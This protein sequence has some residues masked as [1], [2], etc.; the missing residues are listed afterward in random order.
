MS[1]LER[2]R[3]YILQSWLNPDNNLYKAASLH[4]RWSLAIIEKHQKKLDKYDLGFLRQYTTCSIMWNLEHR[5]RFREI[6]YSLSY[7]F[8]TGDMKI[9]DVV[10]NIER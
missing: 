7:P 2:N 9:W 10:H 4:M 3:E 5:K 1:T 6:A 8:P